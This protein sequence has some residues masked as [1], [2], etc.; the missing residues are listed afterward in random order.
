[1]ALR[2][3]QVL[4]ENK[5][6]AENISQKTGLCSFLTDILAAR[7]YDEKT[8]ETFF[9]EVNQLNDPFLLPDMGK[10]V[11]RVNLAIHNHEK[12][13]I[14]GDYDVDGITSVVILMK[15]LKKSDANVN[16]YIPDRDTE[17]YGLNL[18][19]IEKFK[20]Q[21]VNLIITVDNG[22]VSVDEID[23]A[24]SLNIDVIVTDHHTIRTKLPAAVAVVNPMREEY[25]GL[26]KISGVVVALK[27]IMALAGDEFTSIFVDYAELACM[28]TVS[29]V[30][31]ILKE[32]H[33]IVKIGL[34]SLETSQNPG[35]KALKQIA[36]LNHKQ[37]TTTD[38][39]F[40]LAPRLNAAARLNSTQLAIDLLL[41]E[42]ENKCYDIA[43][44]IEKK[45]IERKKV[46]KQ[47]LDE[48]YA[49]LDAFPNELNRRIIIVAGDGWHHG[50]I[51]IVA[52]KIC[53]KFFKP[54]LIISYDGEIAK[55]SGRSI[56]E[57][58]LIEAINSVDDLFIKHGGHKTAVG[59][60]MPTEKL[61]D[62][63][64]RLENYARN[65]FNIMPTGTLIIDRIVTGQELTISNI[66]STEFLAP[67]GEGNHSPIFEL[68]NLLINQI[69]PLCNGKYIKFIITSP[70]VIEL[71]CF[72]MN[73]SECIYKPGDIVNAVVSCSVDK[74][75]GVERL[76]IKV[77]D[78]RYSDFNQEQYLEG[79]QLYEN[80][81]LNETCDKAKLKPNREEIVTVYKSI[82][83]EKTPL[84]TDTIFFKIRNFNINYG[85]FRII[86]D[87]LAELSVIIYK[88][89]KVSI[90]KVKE[91]QNIE[92][93]VIWSTLN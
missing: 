63:K 71:L 60:T 32:N 23:F 79:K 45:N 19:S 69:I 76:S 24:N 14:F 3:W 13:M 93:S 15:Y 70:S 92:N 85:K 86:L 10:A 91:K 30:M 48:V 75:R 61:F 46:E 7:K 43:L 36:S 54:C 40:G 37:L 57:F 29:D 47:V 73:I 82:W 16:Y 62:L 12:I 8:L 18:L 38:I 2:K 56:D 5:E 83:R 53:N 65:N 20:Q 50:V 33:Y 35:L 22:I 17:G 66:K 51:G 68:K 74:Y 78:L 34:K 77:S 11:E 4:K 52:A 9:E 26:K 72:K 28:G 67:F 49:Y 55:G 90:N 39:S 81:K 58:S 27:L 59:L 1:M 42:N 21:G 84:G 31:P 64:T 41:C 80:F 87:I 88:R 89:D 6:L 25:T 44:A